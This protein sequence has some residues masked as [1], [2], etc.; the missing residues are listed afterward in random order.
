M[1]LKNIMIGIKVTEEL[2]GK[3]EKVAKH[4]RR[5]ISDYIRTEIEKLIEEFELNEYKN[6]SK[7]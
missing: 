6:S 4:N 3:L 7:Q 5:T 2:K 1:S